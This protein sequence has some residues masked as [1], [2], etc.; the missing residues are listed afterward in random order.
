MTL[1]GKL[2]A[3][4]PDGIVALPEQ[5]LVLVAD[6][7][8]GVVWRVDTTTAEDEV[9]IFNDA[10]EP[11]SEV[12]LG[13]NGLHITA[14]NYLYFTNS[15]RH[16]LGKLSIDERGS[17]AGPVKIVTADLVFPD[18]FALR[19]DGTAYVAGDNTLWQIDTQGNAKVLAGG[20]NDLVLEGVTSAQFG[21]T[22]IDQD[23]L[24][25][26]MQFSISL[27]CPY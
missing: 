25:L 9:A 24:Y 10:F 26:G 11:T 27:K 4:L 23:V 13:V 3:P 20:A 5:D 18:D 16:L 2:S 12:L 1:I 6:A 19:A 7:A 14:N 21:R 22:S 8:E 15:A 17:Q